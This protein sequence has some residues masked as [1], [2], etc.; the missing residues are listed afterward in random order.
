MLLKIAYLVRFVELVVVN[1]LFTKLE[2]LASRA[3]NLVERSW[4]CMLLLFED[5]WSS[6]RGLEFEQCSF[7]KK[8]VNTC[9]NE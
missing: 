3:L 1:T 4:F 7:C 6:F 9:A 2:Y 5:V 8:M